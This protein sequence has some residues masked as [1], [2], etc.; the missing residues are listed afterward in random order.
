LALRQAEFDA[1]QNKRFLWNEEEAATGALTSAAVGGPSARV[2]EGQ[3]LEVT[4]GDSLVLLVS[5]DSSLDSG[6]VGT[7]VKISLASVRYINLFT[8]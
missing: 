4:S 2:I 5:S 8:S 7:E 1:K 6:L 3:C